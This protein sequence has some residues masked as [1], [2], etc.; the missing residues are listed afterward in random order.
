MAS[1]DQASPQYIC[2]CDEVTED[3]I[4]AAMRAGADVYK[5]QIIDNR[6]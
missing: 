4:V 5:R 3:D 1:V 2:Y 6:F